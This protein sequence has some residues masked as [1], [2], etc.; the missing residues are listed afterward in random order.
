MLTSHAIPAPTHVLVHVVHPPDNGVLHTFGLEAIFRA[1]PFEAN[2]Q[3][4]PSSAQWLMVA[5][6]SR[7]DMSKRQSR[8]EAP[9]LVAEFVPSS[10]VDDS[11]VVRP[12][13]WQAP[14]SVAV[15]ASPV[16]PPP[17]LRPASGVVAA[18]QTPPLQLVA[19]FAGHVSLQPSPTEVVR[20][21]LGHSGVQLPPP[22]SAPLSP[23]EVNADG[24]VYSLPSPSRPV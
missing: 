17:S 18:W 23:P 4:A 24:F 6:Q 16:A 21:V 20:Q 13:A 14:A 15:E 10:H 7:G 3:P 9:R 5:A 2:R 1:S 19:Q 12:S 11:H 22:A 8:L